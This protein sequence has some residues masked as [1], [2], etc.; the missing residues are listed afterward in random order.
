MVE[1]NDG[2]KDSFYKIFLKNRENSFG[3]AEYNLYF[4]FLISLHP[5]DYKIRILKY[6][7]T[8][9][10]NPLIERL[11][12]KYHYCSYHSYM[13]KDSKNFLNRVAKFL[14]FKI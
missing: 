7:N 8:S 10:F 4:Y 14:F 1:S 13:R 11:R 9:K 5:N 6:K 3:V 2:N 12:R